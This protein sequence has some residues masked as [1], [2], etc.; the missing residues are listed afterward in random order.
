MD[1]LL[2]HDLGQSLQGPGKH[3]LPGGRA[4]LD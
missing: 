2:G 3:A 4:L 1:I